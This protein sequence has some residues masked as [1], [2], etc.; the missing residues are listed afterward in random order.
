METYK[1]ELTQELIVRKVK[2]YYTKDITVTDDE[3]KE[4]YEY[5]LEVQT[6]NIVQQP[7]AIEQ[8]LLF[9]A[10]ILY[11]PQ[12]YMYA[13]HILV[14]FEAATRGAA[15]IEYVNGNISE[16]NRIINE[17][18]PTVQA[19]VEEIQS[20]LAAGED[21]ATVMEQYSDDK[22]LNEEPYFTNG[23][24]IGSY[25]QFD[26]TEYLDAV[27]TLEHAGDISDPVPTYMGV[28]I[29]EC[30]K[31]LGGPVPLEDVWESLR[32]TMIEQKKAY[33]WSS[34]GESWIEQAESKGI[35]QTYLDRI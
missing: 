15:A 29:I 23:F 16:Y 7:S 27:A 14:S 30:V 26:I 9:G 19:R 33:T 5:E 12:G 35:L 34:L 1:E 21:F 32:N 3:V 28:Y 22:T 31:P 17:A 2:A 4:K 8:N 13:R 24:L 20:K 25:S 10:Q 6:N 11:Y 18:V